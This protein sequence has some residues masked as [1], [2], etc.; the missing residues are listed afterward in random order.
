[1]MRNLMKRSLAAFVA[2]SLC[3]CAGG[4]ARIV[5]AARVKARIGVLADVNLRGA[6]DVQ[7]LKKAFAYYRQEGVDAVA[8]AGTATDSESKVTL[9]EVWREVFG[10]DAVPLFVEPGRY[11]VEGALFATSV[12]RP[13]GRQEVLTFYGKRRLALTDEL[14]IYPRNNRA[15]CAGS[16]SGL[17]LPNGYDNRALGEKL[18][19]SAQGLLVS[20][21]ADK[22]V[23][24]RLDFTQKLPLDPG[25]A[26]EASK[27]RL[28]YAEDV[29]DPW[30]ISADGTVAKP[31]RE[32]PEFWSDTRLQVIPGYDRSERIYT[33]KW[34]S[35]LQRHVGARA[36]WYVVEAVFADAPTAVFL[37]RTV[38]S[39]GYHQAE[40]RDVGAVKIAFRSSQLPAANERHAQ[41]VFKVTPIGAFGKSGKPLVSAAVPLPR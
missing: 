33:V 29:A 7:M 34:P 17:D 6:G 30:V 26:W 32:I 5:D 10:E 2:L 23:I 31:E 3:G 11:E 36:R 1:M 35:L 27:S 41:V 21:Y 25:E 4:V 39:E 28:V 37:S 13:I 9:K 20:V 38:L 15:V 24:R 12:D 22:T 18:A 16:M 14:C 40:D 8:I 19:K